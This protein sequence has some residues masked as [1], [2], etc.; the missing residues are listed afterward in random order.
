MIVI[1]APGIPAAM[2]E[3]GFT[4]GRSSADERRHCDVTVD[5]DYASAPHARFYFRDGIW[6]VEDLGSTNGTWLNWQSIWEPGTR[7]YGP[8]PL[9]KGDKLRIGRTVLTVVPD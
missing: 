3:A 7:V 9:A 2:F 4:I 6:F 8:A 1:Q 5:D